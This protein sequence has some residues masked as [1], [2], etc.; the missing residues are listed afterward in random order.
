M[1]AQIRAVSNDQ[2]IYTYST[3][4]SANQKRQNT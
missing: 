1:I 2:V 4:Q 3:V